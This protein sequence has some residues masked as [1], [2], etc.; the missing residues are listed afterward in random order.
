MGKLPLQGLVDIQVG[1]AFRSAIEQDP[2]GLVGV[3]Q[4]KDLGDDHIVDLAGM[5][6]VSMAV[7][8]S[9]RAREGD[10]I[11]RSRG[12]RSTCA[13]VVG[14]PGCALVAAPLLRLRV[15]D[16][17]LLSAY[18]N[19]FINQPAAQEHFARHA[20]GSRV[21]MINKRVLEDLEI[22]VPSRERQPSIVELAGLWER[23]RLLCS[24]I[25]ATRGRLLTNVMTKYAEESEAQ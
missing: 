7:P 16:D 24:E 25:H 18:V 15:T 6:H 19:W 11:L 1:Y 17:R 9:R 14:D 8:V 22:E 10:I 13:I 4:M 23:E 2:A 5:V 12:D 21:K 20:E 3:I